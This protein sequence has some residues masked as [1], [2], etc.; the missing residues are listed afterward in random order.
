MKKNNYMDAIELRE[1]LKIN[2]DLLNEKF[3]EENY[4]R[5]LELLTCKTEDQYLNDRG[6][7][8]KEVVKNDTDFRLLIG[9]LDFNKVKDIYILKY[10]NSWCVE[11]RNTNSSNLNFID[12]FCGAGGLSLG[13]LQEGFDVNFACDIE[14]ACIE[15][16][17]FNHPNVPSK[18]IV[19]DD[20]KKYRK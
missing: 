9:K 13:F 6:I 18:Y 3:C 15:T 5:N 12:L 8:F 2:K 4:S 10:F 11:Q 17:R 1:I 19:N 16:Y 20:I 14:E 7:K